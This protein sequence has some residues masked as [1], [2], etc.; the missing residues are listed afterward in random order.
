MPPCRRVVD[1][2]LW[3]C[4]H[5]YPNMTGT[6]TP[7][8]TP[9]SRRAYNS[10][11]RGSTLWPHTDCRHRWFND[12]CLAGF[13]PLESSGLVANNRV[14]VSDAVKENQSNGLGLTSVKYRRTVGKT[15]GVITTKSRQ[16]FIA[17]HHQTGDCIR[18]TLIRQSHP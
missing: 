16:I 5:H 3:G 11:C 1:A 7:C 12:A 18:H 15:P 17:T 6:R 10:G 13:D 9:W 4:L 2:L 14:F 8:R